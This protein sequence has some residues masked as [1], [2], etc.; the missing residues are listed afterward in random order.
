M[1][2]LIVPNVYDI[3]FW[4]PTSTKIL[5]KTTSCTSVHTARSAGSRDLPMH[6]SGS[7]FDS[8]TPDYWQNDKQLYFVR[9]SVFVESKEIFQ[10]FN[11]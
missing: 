10:R 1:R 7:H 6:E 5:A 9:F 11:L 2:I 3:Q 8:Q 4:A